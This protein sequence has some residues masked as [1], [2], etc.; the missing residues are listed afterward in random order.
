MKFAFHS[1]DATRLTT[2]LIGLYCFEDGFAEGAIFRALDKALDGLLLRVAEGE[3]FKAKKGQTLLLHTHGRVGPER[4]LLVGAGARK[5][6]AAPDLR[7]FAARV[8][9]A[10]A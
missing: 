6:F 8:Y 5:D 1:D 3:Q 7:G 9:K 4:V 2:G 10:A